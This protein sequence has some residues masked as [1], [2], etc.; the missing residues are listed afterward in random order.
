[1]IYTRTEIFA[2]GCFWSCTTMIRFHLV[3]SSCHSK[4]TIWRCMFVAA[5]V[6]PH[7]SIHLLVL[8][9]A[10][11]HWA[12]LV[13]IGDVLLFFSSPSV[14]YVHPGQVHGCFPAEV[15]F[16]FLD[17]DFVCLKNTW[18]AS[19]IS[20]SYVKLH[21]PAFRCLIYSSCLY[22]CFQMIHWVTSY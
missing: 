5:T 2:L 4:M 7:V 10:L 1:M 11:S 19:R 13:G 9:Q 6:H 15:F 20:M 21:R 17:A 14:M 12:T 22:W 8:A 18:H 16:P 3:V